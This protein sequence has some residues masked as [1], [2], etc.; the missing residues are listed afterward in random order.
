MSIKAKCEHVSF[1]PNN[2]AGRCGNLA[3]YRCYSSHAK[4]KFSICFDCYQANYWNWE[5]ENEGP[6]FDINSTRGWMQ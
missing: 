3:I 4:R 5:L 2:E 6:P 1:L